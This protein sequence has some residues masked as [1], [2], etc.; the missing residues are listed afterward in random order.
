[1]LINP[2]H[3]VAKNILLSY[4]RKTNNSL[5]A[6]I[7]LYEHSLFHEAQSLIRILFEL[8][9]TL[10]SFVDMLQHDPIEACKR[11]WDSVML[12]KV[13]Q[14][15]ASNFEGLDLIP[16]AP[17]REQLIETEDNIKRR[18][19]NADLGKIRK[20]G[21]SG[22]NVEQRAKQAGLSSIYDIVYRNFS[23]NIHS[24]DIME[25]TLLNDPEIIVGLHFTN[26][27]ESRD[28]VG[29]EVIFVSVAGTI[30]I[31]NKIFR[32]DFEQPLNQLIN[33]RGSLQ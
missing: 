9:T 31:F 28:L 4:L 29:C 25:L 11:V 3:D 20:N 16:G 10:L 1:M 18:Y 21:F 24:T 13:K 7:M 27:V 33:R 8:H 2:E 5:E 12:E 30:D 14:Q 15:R 6:I 17:S 19:S 22:L 32:L 26:Y 23:R